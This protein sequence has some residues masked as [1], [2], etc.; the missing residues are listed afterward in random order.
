[1]SAPKKGSRLEAK[2]GK[3][4]NGNI[5]ALLFMR[6]QRFDLSLVVLATYQFVISFVQNLSRGCHMTRLHPVLSSNTQLNL[7]S[8]IDMTPHIS[9]SWIKE[10]SPQGQGGQVFLSI[11]KNKHTDL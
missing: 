8:E 9:L 5:F 2:V 11:L 1:M 6:S 3:T 4:L 7:V 10:K